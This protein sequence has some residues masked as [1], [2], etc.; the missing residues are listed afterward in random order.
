MKLINKREGCFETNSSSS[1][2]IHIRGESK[3][4]WPKNKN[5]VYELEFD[6]FGWGIT[7]HDDFY[8]KA[9]Y[10]LTAIGSYINA[11]ALEDIENSKHYKEF[12]RIIAEAT[13]HTVIVSE[14]GGYH[15]LG[16]IDHQ[17]SDFARGLVEALFT[18]PNF[19]KRYLFDSSFIL[20]IDND[21]H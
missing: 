20:N 6:E 11:D 13:G 17:S 14:C 10:L 9:S 12:V 1:H 19:I 7:H 2:S 15:K 18:K 8:T 4:G 16:Y 5:K 21:N 3:I